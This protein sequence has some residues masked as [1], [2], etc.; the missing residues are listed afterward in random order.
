MSL[1]GAIRMFGSKVPYPRGGLDS[2]VSRIALARS[3]FLRPATCVEFLDVGR[4]SCSGFHLLPASLALVATAFSPSG[5]HAQAISFNYSDFSGA[6]SSISTKGNAS[7]SGSNLVLTPNTGNQSGA[8]WLTSPFRIG[9]GTTFQSTFTFQLNKDSPQQLTPADGFTFVIASGTSSLGSSGG[10]LGYAGASNSVAVSFDTYDNGSSDGN[11]SNHV[12]VLSNGSTNLLTFGN[13]Y[14]QNCDT[15]ANGGCNLANGFLSNSHIWTGTVSYD[16]S[17]I[18][19]IVMDPAEGYATTVISNYAINIPQLL[20]S[21]TAYVGFTG[22]TGSNGESHDILS[23]NM[24]TTLPDIR[25]ANLNNLSDLTSLFN[26]RFDGGTLI[27]DSNGATSSAAYAVT[28]NGGS[29]DING[30]NATFSGNITDDSGS[31]GGRLTVKD[32]GSGGKVTL[33]GTNTFTG[34]LRIESGAEVSIASSAALGSG[35]LQMAAP[36]SSATLDTTGNTTIANAIGLAGNAVFNVATGTIATLTGAIT[37]LGGTAGTKDVA[38]AI[39]EALS[40]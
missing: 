13:P 34:G 39:F 26:A 17:Q 15:H 27:V 14:G 7:I 40:A 21:T 37:D 2:S 23:W 18:S 24:A 25:A 35:A 6:S 31:P 1:I 33:A 10:G 8:A 29:I 4:S 19:V 3:R 20:N 16:G 9:A 38:K 5:A 28:A 30:K 36:S 12:G 32:S 11:S 22:S